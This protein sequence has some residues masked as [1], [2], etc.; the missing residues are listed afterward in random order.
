MSIKI[1]FMRKKI[2]TFLALSTAIA[3]LLSS[4]LVLSNFLLQ[5]VQAQ[6]PMTFKTPKPATYTDPDTGQV[7]T[8]TFDAQGTATPSGPQAAKI[9]NGTIQGHISGSNGNGPQTFTGNITSGFYSTNRYP[10]YITFYATIQNA[11]Y[12]VESACTA[13]ADNPIVVGPDGS[14]GGTILDGEFSGAVECSPS[15]SGGGGGNTTTATDT[16]TTPPPQQQPSSSPMTGSSQDGNRGSGS[17]STDSN[18]NSKDSD[19]DGIPDSSDKCT[20]NSNPKCFKEGGTSN[21]TTTTPTTH[22]Q[23]PSSS[24]SSSSDNRTGNQTR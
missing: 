5:P 21:T 1:P 17:N 9:T 10:P 3:L 24:P 11:D 19:S 7:F 18:S 20:H 16:P 22:E 13:S 14:S 23:Q 12:Y 6:S 4:P 2:S 15:Q 8:L